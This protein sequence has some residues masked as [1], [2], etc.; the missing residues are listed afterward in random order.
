MSDFRQRLPAESFQ[1]TV[2]MEPSV[3]TLRLD[4]AAEEIWVPAG[5]V[6]PAAG[7]HAPVAG[8]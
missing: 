2:T 5:P 7:L 1:D 4:V 8:S 6:E 3:V